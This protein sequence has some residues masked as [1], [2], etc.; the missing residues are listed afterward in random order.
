MVVEDFNVAIC[1]HLLLAPTCLLAPFTYCY[2]HICTYYLLLLAC[3][4]RVVLVTYA[5]LQL[6]G[7]MVIDEVS[8][9]V[10]SNYNQVSLQ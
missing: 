9:G 3:F 1:K 2:L 5:T 6:Y 10:L 4:P 8:L 7:D